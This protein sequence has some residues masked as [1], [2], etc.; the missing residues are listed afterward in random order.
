LK[1]K[2]M[3]KLL[4]STSFFYALDILVNSSQLMVS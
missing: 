2:I 1:D 4:Q 3:L